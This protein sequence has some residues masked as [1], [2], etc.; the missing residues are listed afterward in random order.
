MLRMRSSSRSYFTR[1]IVRH[2]AMPIEKYQKQANILGLFAFHMR[3]IAHA[4]K[5]QA[6]TRTMH[7]H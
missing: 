2:V 6:V 4:A 3:C 1:F 7:G 5:W